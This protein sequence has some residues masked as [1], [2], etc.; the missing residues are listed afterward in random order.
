VSERFE[1]SP[2]TSTIHRVHVWFAVYIPREGCVCLEMSLPA[3]YTL[4]MFGSTFFQA[5]LAV[6]STGY[7]CSVSHREGC[8]PGKRIVRQQTGI[9]QQWSQASTRPSLTT[10]IP[11]PAHRVHV[12]GRV[13]PTSKQPSLQAICGQWLFILTGRDACAVSNAGDGGWAGAYSVCCTAPGI[14]SQSL[15]M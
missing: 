10:G 13:P 6:R 5:P 9:P 8:A 11:I 2:C 15:W 14:S 7:V 1:T 12:T 3:E 4:H